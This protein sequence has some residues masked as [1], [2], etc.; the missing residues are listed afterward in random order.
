MPPMSTNRVVVDAPANT[1]RGPWEEQPI[2]SALPAAVPQTDP[3]LELSEQALVVASQNAY[4]IVAQQKTRRDSLG[5]AAGGAV[6]LVLG[7]AT[8]A[9]LNSGRHTAPVPATSA[10]QLQPRGGVPMVT[11]PVPG[12]PMGMPMPAGAAPVP[13]P[14][15][16]P[17]AGMNQMPGT[18]PIPGMAPV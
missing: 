13:T 7:V 4:P 5:L 2:R 3:R 12:K 16:A 15:T 6:A 14:Q 11:A 1:I 10:T 18:M 8:F 17:M 9:S